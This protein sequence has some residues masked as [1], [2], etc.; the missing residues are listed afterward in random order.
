MDDIQRRMDDEAWD[1]SESADLGH[2]P[3]DR[4]DLRHEV[5]LAGRARIG[6]VSARSRHQFSCDDAGDLSPKILSLMMRLK[7]RIPHSSVEI[8]RQRSFK[9]V[10][11]ASARMM[12]A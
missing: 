5:D 10:P 6:A 1:E 3:S 11:F 9:T 12:E 7:S 8:V 2:R 4:R